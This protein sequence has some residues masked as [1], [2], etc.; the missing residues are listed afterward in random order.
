MQNEVP[1]A[2][3]EENRLRFYCPNLAVYM[4]RPHGMKVI[5]SYLGRSGG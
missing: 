5:G 4:R 3:E 2:G 1:K